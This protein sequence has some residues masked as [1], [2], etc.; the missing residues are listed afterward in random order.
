[1]HFTLIVTILTLVQLA[2]KMHTS[3][4]VAEQFCANQLPQVP[5]TEDD[6]N[7][8]LLEVNLYG[9]IHFTMTNPHFVPLVQIDIDVA[10]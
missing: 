2:T 5:I 6:G 1:M 4:G 8:E 9:C 7:A 3:T 10:C